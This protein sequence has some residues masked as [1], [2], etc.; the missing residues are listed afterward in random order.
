MAFGMDDSGFEEDHVALLAELTS[1]AL[2][3][4]PVSLGKLEEY[5]FLL[6]CKVLWRFSN[7]KHMC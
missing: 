2:L 7:T 6:S 4:Q 1:Q 5:N 3:H